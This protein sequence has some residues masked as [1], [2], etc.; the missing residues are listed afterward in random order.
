M[1]MKDLDKYIKLWGLLPEANPIETPSSLLLPVAYKNKPAYLKVAK[2]SEERFGNQLMAW[3]NGKGAAPILEQRDDALLMERALINKNLNKLCV[4]NQDSEATTILTQVANRLHAVRK[5]PLIK[6]LTPLHQRFRSLMVAGNH[7]GGRLLKAAL[8]AK[9]LLATSREEVVLHGDLHH[10]NVLYFE[11]QGWLA[12]DPKGLYGERGYEFASLFCN[13][14]FDLATKPG[15]VKDQALLVAGLA[16]LNYKRLMQWVVA[17]AGL[18][19]AWHLEDGTKEGIA[20]AVL[21]IALD[22]LVD[23]E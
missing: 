23:L 15:R 6:G 4:T 19:A 7:H 13:P 20:L 3:W 22:L 5:Q 8:V 9:K 14:D 16:G 10:A 11:E 12:V 17:H 18:S 2:I 1:S 21:S